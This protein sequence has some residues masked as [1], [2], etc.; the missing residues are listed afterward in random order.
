MRGLFINNLKKN[1]S[2]SL[3][4][5]EKANDICH[6]GHDLEYVAA[7]DKSFFDNIPIYVCANYYIPSEIATIVQNL[8]K[9]T[10]IKDK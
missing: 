4:K 1:D 10:L 8:S 2:G 7:H 3:S 5:G 9:T 6:L